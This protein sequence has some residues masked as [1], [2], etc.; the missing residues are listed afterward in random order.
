MYICFVFSLFNKL[1]FHQKHYP[2]LNYLKIFVYDNVNSPASL[3][4]LHKRIAPI[5]KL[6]ESNNPLVDFIF[7]VLF[8]FVFLFILIIHYKF[9]FALM[10]F[11]VL[12]LS[13]HI[14]VD[15]LSEII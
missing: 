2:A 15:I 6:Y 5:S 10:A 1:I 9:L 8:S 3:A 14:Y 11:S 7:P 12:H 13:P 4:A